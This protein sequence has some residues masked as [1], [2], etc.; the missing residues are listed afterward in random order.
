MNSVSSRTLG[1]IVIGGVLYWFAVALT[2][3]V[4][5]PEFS[6]IRAPMS[7]YVLGVH[8]PWM[9][10]TYFAWSAALLA[11]GYGVVRTLPRMRLTKFA[12]ALFLIAAAGV[13]LA[14]LFPMDFP[15]PPRTSSGR[16][17]ATGGL[18]AFPTTA[19]GAFLFS[20][21]FRRDRYWRTV[22]GPILALSTVS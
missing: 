2:M 19:L 15:G 9:T 3:H 18:F 12:F 8:S 21:S 20:L 6:T 7:V 4:L 22:S 5:E 1:L 16:L 10:T 14:G 11:L 17:H 13:L